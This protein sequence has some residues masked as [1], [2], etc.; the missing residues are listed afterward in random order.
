MYC[1]TCNEFQLPKFKQKHHEH[2]I[3]I[4]IADYHLSRPSE[5]LDPL[6]NP[7]K[8]AQYLF[9]RIAVETIVNILCERNVR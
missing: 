9:S 8:E 2:I 3:K 1:V 5:F 6:D 4:D 7:K